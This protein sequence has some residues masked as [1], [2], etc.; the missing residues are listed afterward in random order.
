MTEEKDMRIAVD[1]KL[2][3]GHGRCYDV[4]PDVFTPDDEGFC[5]ERGTAFEV[6]PGVE[7]AARRGADACPER[8]ITVLVEARPSL[9][10]G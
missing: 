7:E 10:D 9:V 2:C 6:A 3:S 8:A 4:S 5:G 1:G